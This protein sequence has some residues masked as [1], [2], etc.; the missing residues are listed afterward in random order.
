MATSSSS[1]WHNFSTRVTTSLASALLEW[2]LILFLF[3]SAIFSYV[4]TKFARYCNLKSPCLFCSR[5]DHVLGKQKRGY[6]F[7]LIC[8]VHKSEISSLVFCRKHDK[9]VNIHG[10][11][12]T[13]ILSSA[14]IDKSNAVTSRLLVGKSG[15]EEEP[16]SVF[17]CDPLLGERIIA[18]H[19]SCCS[20]KFRLNDYDQNLVFAKSIR[21]RAVDFDVSDV[22][23][24]DF[25]EK[26]SEKP[27]VSVRD[28]RVRNDHADPLSRVGYTELNI[29]SD[30]ESEFEVPLSDDD[31]ISIPI[32]GKDDTKEDIMVSCE[33]MELR[34]VD[35]NEDLTSG[36]PGASAS[37]LEPLLSEPGE[38][39]EN[40]DICRGTKTAAATAESGNGLS[41]LDWQQIERTDVCPSPSE[42]R[43]FND[44][45]TLSNKTEVPVEVSKENCKLFIFI[46]FLYH[47]ML[48][49][50]A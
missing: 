17:D 8:T 29:T 15:R 30:T 6:Y 42:P 26:R 45:P 47:I 32:R 36:K 34:S 50:E 7:D 37:V 28:A 43:S 31:G 16:G 49:F 14:I 5:L 39:V 3:T 35:S 4:I 33:Y 38:Q 41:E 2:L 21:S 9:L 46:A 25:Y 10:V 20:E 44:V 19:C 11:C 23:G 1:R 27:F 40:R 22:D 18:G 13:C 24:N 12:E 48:G